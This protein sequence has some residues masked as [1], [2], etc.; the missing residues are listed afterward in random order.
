MP[1]SI[2]TITQQLPLLDEVYKYASLTALLDTDN[3]LVQYSQNAHE[4]KFA[5]VT[6]QGLGDYSRS[7]GFVAGDISLTWETHQFKYDRGRSFSIDAMDDLETLGLAFASTASTFIR[8]KVV[9]EMDA[10]RFATYATKA[11]NSTSATL[12]NATAI[13]AIDTAEEV[14]QNAEVQLADC[15]L[16]MS[17]EIYKYVKQ[18]TGFT[19]TLV[20]SEN[21]NRNFGMF[22]DME[23]V[24]VP[25][26]RF[27]T[28]VTL[29]NGSS[30]G[31]TDGGYIK[32]SDGQQINFMI[33]DPEA[34]IQ[35]VKH[36]VPRVFAPDVNQSADA[37]KIDY[38]VYH[39]VDVY[40]N[41][42][43]GIYCHKIPNA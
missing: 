41:K 34:V 15:V 31:Q 20:P 9:P 4:Y 35:I 24:V 1:N 5:K 3:A 28:K 19:R 26:N 39:D 30:S 18:S 33:V 17:P 29:Y 22:D 40:D 11:G 13:G 36:A 37:Y 12:T 38:R 14:L 16:F 6:T 27:V 7:T 8:T 21:P 42:V 25:A 32:A 43:N 23:V 10:V 2:T